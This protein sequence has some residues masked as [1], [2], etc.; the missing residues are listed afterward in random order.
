V[1]GDAHERES[2]IRKERERSEE[3]AKLGPGDMEVK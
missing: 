3:R 2:P 1:G